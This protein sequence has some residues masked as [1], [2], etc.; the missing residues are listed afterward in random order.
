MTAGYAF[1]ILCY[2]VAGMARP[3]PI[4]KRREA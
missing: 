4:C 1:A 2:N 3:H